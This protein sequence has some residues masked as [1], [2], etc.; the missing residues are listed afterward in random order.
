M[1]NQL[2]ITALAENTAG[3]FDVAGEW[4]LSL[5]IQADHHRILCDTGGGQSI[6]YNSRLLGIDL[7]TAD[8][9][10]I[11]HGHYDHTGGLSALVDGGFRGKIY[12]HPAALDTKYSRQ[13]KVPHKSVGIPA[14]SRQVL[15][16]C[17]A[18]FIQSAGPTEIAPGIVLTGSIPRRNRFEDSYDKAHFLDENC[19][20]PDLFLDDQALLIQTPRGWAV[21]TGCCHAGLINTLEYAVELTGNGHMCAV[22]GGLHL[23]NAPPERV[24][25]TIEKMEAF[26]VELLAPC[27]CTG[28]KPIVGLQQRFGS[29][30]VALQAG[31][32]L[33]IAGAAP[34][35]E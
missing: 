11:S 21:I 10:V 2:S 22:L 8:I 31:V 23:F 19:T 3:V 25:A 5:W 24:E 4:G 32:T 16:S 18:D 13:K 33:T 35:T 9:L 14:A 20:Q 17:G 28:F 6:E 27:H 30:F 7:A 26:G 1:I 12:A 15:Q 29:R 34:A